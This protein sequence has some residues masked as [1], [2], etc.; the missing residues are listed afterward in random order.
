ML[1]F[2][3]LSEQLVALR[4]QQHARFGGTRRLLGRC[5]LTTGFIVTVNWHGLKC[6]RQSLVRGREQWVFFTAFKS[7]EEAG[8]QAGWTVALRQGVEIDHGP[9]VHID[10]L[11]ER[12]NF[13]RRTAEFFDARP[14]APDELRVLLRVSVQSHTAT[15]QLERAGL[16]GAHMKSFFQLMVQSR[17]DCG[18]FVKAICVERKLFV[19]D[20][21]EWVMAQ[22]RHSARYPVDKPCAVRVA[23][24]RIKRLQRTG[25]ECERQSVAP[26]IR[27]VDVPKQPDRGTGC[28]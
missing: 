6:S 16:L 24:A 11:H 9:G 20:G 18:L 15:Q 1:F 13:V 27:P 17:L 25:V 2:E 19:T 8:E 4:E 14:A 28:K 12:R 26:Y 5:C 21:R 10:P 7:Q 3:K 22:R 23:F